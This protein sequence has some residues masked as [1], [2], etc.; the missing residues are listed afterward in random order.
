[1]PAAE[2]LKVAAMEWL[3]PRSLTTIDELQKLEDV[4]FE[5]QG[6]HQFS[7]VKN[8]LSLPLPTMNLKQ[9]ADIHRP[10]VKKSDKNF[11]DTHVF[12]PIHDAIGKAGLTKDELSAIIFI[13][14]S[15]SNPLVR[16]AV[17][18]ELPKGI[19]AIIPP[20][21]QRHVSLGATYHSMCYH[22][23]NIDMIR[24]IT[25]ES[26]FIITKGGNH[27]VII[28]A[29]SVV[30]TDKDHSITL[31][32]PKA[33]QKIIELPICVGNENKLLGVVKI[34]SP[35]SVGFNVG[36]YVN[37]SASI[38]HEKLL[39]IKVDV[40]GI[41]VKSALM[42]PLA[43]RPLSD[44]EKKVL[45]AKQAFNKALLEYGSK[46]PVS[47]VIAYAEASQKA[48]DFETAADMYYAAQRLDP[49]LSHE[50]EICYC[51]SV[52]GKKIKSEEWGQKAYERQPNAVSAY[53]LAVAKTGD[54]K[55]ELLKE[56]LK[57]DPYF[58]PALNVLGTIYV[59]NGNTL[60][61]AYL[62]E[63][64]NLLKPSISVSGNPTQIKQ[65]LNIIINASNLLND[66]DNLK[67]AERQLLLLD[68]ISDRNKNEP[69]NDANLIKSK[70]SF[71]IIKGV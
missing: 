44:Q 49:T 19:V 64:I 66:V 48:G 31:E 13:G 52:A 67:W 68:N 25:P 23:L 39:E 30:P 46:P 3:T 36:E 40:S 61:N 54:D 71:D 58:V 29:S 70:S 14:G 56:C 45:E 16:K 43:N 33:R 65:N 8:K 15:C 59:K 62:R 57:H 50:T 47:V 7:I 32:V 18:N 24:P 17:L 38:T 37:V 9:L 26:I 28:P 41:S 5:T 12:A 27:D 51:Y 10:F 11:S 55:V 34:S 22:G 21:L 53:N 2:R 42:N 20:D 4:K 69:Y 63:C 1:M 35:S 60:G 6:I